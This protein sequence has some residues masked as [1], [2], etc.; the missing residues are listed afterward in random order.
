MLSKRNKLKNLEILALLPRVKYFSYW[1]CPWTYPW[2]L[3]S[4][5]SNCLCQ[6]LRQTLGC[7]HRRDHWQESRSLVAGL[8]PCALH[9]CYHIFRWD[10][11]HRSRDVESRQAAPT[12]S[13]RMETFACVWIQSKKTFFSRS[14]NSE[15]MYHGEVDELSRNLPFS[16]RIPLQN[17]RWYKPMP[18]HIM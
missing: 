3:K 15:Q 12:P 16:H 6:A 11:D 4:L 5:T 9:N 13:R 10:Q 8:V 7:V 18:V 17:V 14:S 2:S 1:G